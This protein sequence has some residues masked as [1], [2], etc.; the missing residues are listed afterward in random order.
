MLFKKG[1]LMKKFLLLI[2]FLLVSFIA[3]NSASAAQ[4]VFVV[5]ESGSMSGEH[6]WLNGM[7]NSLDTA[8]NA[9]GV[10]NN[11]YG[12]VGFGSSS[13]APRTVRA[14]GALPASNFTT[15][16]V[17]SGGTEDGYAGI[18]YA[19]T[20]AGFGLDQTQAVNVI[21]VTDEDRDNWATSLNYN[22]IRNLF[23][24]NAILNAVVNGFFRD[25]SGARALGIDADGNAYIADGSGGYTETTGGTSSTT[26]D[27]GT[28]T[29]DYVALALATGGG[30]WDLNLLRAGGLVAD[31]FTQAFIDIKVQETV[32]IDNNPVPEPATMLLFGLGLLGLAGVNRRKA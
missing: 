14:M 24:P 31:S 7:V 21:L 2:S 16:L 17:I 13:V 23:G 9:A 3:I 1:G 26:Q 18:N 27:F 4:I 29:E 20:N 22:A 19:F 10:V 8:L 28:T 12:I 11:E 15:G 30:A 5:D 25:A 6:A 32:I